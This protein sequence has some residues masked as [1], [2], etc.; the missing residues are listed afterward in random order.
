VVAI[1]LLPKENGTTHIEHG[2][3]TETLFFNDDDV[4]RC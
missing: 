4:A 2:K 1:P 3:E